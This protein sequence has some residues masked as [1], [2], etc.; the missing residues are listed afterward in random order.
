MDWAGFVEA[1]TAIN[2]VTYL[3]TADGT[4]RPH[5][6]VVAPGFSEGSVWF[7]TRPA[8]KKLRN[9]GENPRVGF[10]WPVGGQGPGEL[11]A[12][13]TATIQP[14]DQHQGIWNAGIFAYDLD[15]FFGAPD[16]PD[17]AFVQVAISRAR[18]IGPDFVADRYP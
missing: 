8:S 14:T 6:S 9:I 13:G 7:A 11:A 17:L 15:Q 12:W 3:G 5:V 2:W 10:H 1:A 18:L 16:N 4:G